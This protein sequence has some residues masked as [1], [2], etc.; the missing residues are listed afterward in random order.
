MQT[1]PYE[2]QLKRPVNQGLLKSPQ[3]MTKIQVYDLDENK[4]VTLPSYS[5]GHRL[6]IIFFYIK[7]CVPSITHLNY[8]S[9][10]GSSHR[11]Q[12]IIYF[13]SKIKKFYLFFF[14]LFK[15]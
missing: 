14:L 5:K 15:A 12:V 3:I 11:A 2:K 13:I 8:F 1:L 6:S 4:K 7:R 10:Y 9:T